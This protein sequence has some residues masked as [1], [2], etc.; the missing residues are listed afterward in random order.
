MICTCRF[1]SR[2]CVNVDRNLYETYILNSK[3]EWIRQH[4][5]TFYFSKCYGGIVFQ[6]YEIV[7]S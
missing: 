4:I 6:T 7:R 3:Y 2:T 5:F 1:A